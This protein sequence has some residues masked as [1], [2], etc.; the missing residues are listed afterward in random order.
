MDGCTRREN[1]RRKL[2]HYIVFEMKTF[3]DKISTKISC[4]RSVIL[5]LTPA[6]EETG[7]DCRNS[8]TP[9]HADDE[10]HQQ[11]TIFL[12]HSSKSCFVCV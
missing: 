2:K 3:S 5:A 7:L 1:E 10:K 11:A 12:T 8:Y 4:F 9:S 6:S